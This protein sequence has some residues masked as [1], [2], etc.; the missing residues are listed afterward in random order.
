MKEEWDFAKAN[1]TVPAL[2]PDFEEWAREQ[3]FDAF[4]MYAGNMTFYD[5]L[6]NETKGKMMYCSHC[7]TWS[8]VYEKIQAREIR[9]CPECSASGPTYFVRMKKEPVKCYQSLFIGQ[10]C[11]NGVFVLRLFRTRLLQLSPFFVGQGDDTTVLE[12]SET[13]RMFITPK[14]MHMEYKSWTIRNNK[15]ELEWATNPGEQSLCDGPVYPGTYDEAKG[16]AAEYAFLQ[17]AE[18]RGIY[19]AGSNISDRWTPA[20]YYKQLS[21]WEYLR[22]Y[23]QDRKTEMLLKLGLDDLITFRMTRGSLHH[24][25]RA[26]NPWDYLRIDKRYLKGLQ[27]SVYQM[28]YLRVAQMA[29]KAKEDWD[30]EQIEFV[31]DNTYRQKDIEVILEYMTLKQLTNRIGTYVTRTGKTRGEVTKLYL[32]YLGMKKKLGFDMT[33]SVYQYPKD[34]PAA[35]DKAVEELESKNI[36]EKCK[37]REKMY[38]Q[39]RERFK[40]AKKIY[41]YESGT[42]LIRPAESASEIIRE[43]RFLHHCVGG[44]TYLSEHNKGEGIILLLR[45]KNEQNTPYVTVELNARSEIEQ[46]YG[47][48]DRKPDEKKVDRWLKRY[49]KQLDKKKVRRE[50]KGA[51]V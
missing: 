18:E 22:V 41:T 50:M 6:G 44:D 47:M 15:W 33:N 3:F 43:G 25:W 36:D 31:A 11:G 7:R 46:W 8:D 27:S 48:C 39:I 23:G 42:L 38:P 9:Q 34:L 26:K 51:A 4:V 28:R 21:I 13:R 12:A 40:K 17:L 29:T 16:T 5:D 20:P 49:L 45:K 1:K 19:K 10:N 14:G 32:D 35:H 30:E 24:N 2:P 37:T